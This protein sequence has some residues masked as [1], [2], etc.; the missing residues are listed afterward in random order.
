M[1]SLSGAHHAHDT[2]F[3]LPYLTL[4]NIHFHLI[5]S[6]KYMIYPYPYDDRGSEGGAKKK[7]SLRRSTTSRVRD[8]ISVRRSISFVASKE[9]ATEDIAE[10]VSSQ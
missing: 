9:Q 8:D 3:C 1:D 7:V 6:L 10:M 5:L 4:F 2:I